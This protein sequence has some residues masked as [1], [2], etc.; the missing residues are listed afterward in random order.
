M[1][2]GE[3]ARLRCC[4]GNS[5]VRQRNNHEL[6]TSASHTRASVNRDVDEHRFVTHFSVAFC[7]IGCITRRVS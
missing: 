6:A 3:E 5:F 7:F 4:K 1:R 2:R